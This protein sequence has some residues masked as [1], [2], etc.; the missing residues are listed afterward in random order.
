MRSWRRTLGVKAAQAAGTAFFV[1]V[2]A[3]LLVRLVPGDPAT[4]ILGAKATP[5]AAAALRE[6]LH[7]NHSLPEQFWLYIS[8]LF[9]GDLGHSVV[10]P[11]ESV[12]SIIGETLP[13]TFSVVAAAIVI[14]V[15]VGVPLGLWAATTRW[16]AID[17][18]VRT[19]A[20]LFLATPTF[21]LGLLLILVFALTLGIFPAGGWGEGWPENVEYAV[22]PAI[23]LSGYLTPLIV[24]TVRQAAIAAGGQQFVEA[25]IARGVPQRSIVLGH[26]LPNSLL[27]VVTLVGI[28][29]GALVTGAVVVEAVFGL[30]GLGSELVEAVGVRDYPVIQGIA[31]V[32]ALCVVAANL[33]ADALYIF[34]D[35]RTRRA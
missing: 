18:G 5:A 13:T 22:L 35:P 6:Q 25:A 12:V 21:F 1:M 10:H 15:G 23:A 27:P 19:V 9:Q 30:P 29:V 26:I 28:N 11:Q 3:F 20:V 24:R 4:G 31:V 8:D 32:S 33:L 16:G 34:I 17:F 7:L 2:V 14:S